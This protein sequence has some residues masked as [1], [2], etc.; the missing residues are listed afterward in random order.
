MTKDELHNF[1]NSDSKNHIKSRKFYIFNN[2]HD[3]FIKIMNH[4]LIFFNNR[5]ELWN[6]ILFHY[7][8]DI[9]ILPKCKNEKCNN[10][11]KFTNGIGYKIYCS[12]NCTQQSINFKK[13]RK[14]NNFKKYGVEEFMQTVDFKEKSKKTNLIKY[15]VENPMQNYNVKEKSKKTN[16]IKYG[17]ENPSQS[18]NV[19]NKKR[20]TLFNKKIIKYSKKLKILP[21]DITL[22]SNGFYVIKNYCKLHN[23]FEISGSNIY[24]RIHLKHE[25]IC[26]E[27]NPI[28]ENASILENE[29]RDYINNNLNVKTEKFKL[30]KKDVDIYLP[31]YK[32]GIEFDGLYWHSNKFK[33]DDCQLNKT[34]LCEKQNIKLLHVF[35]DEWLYK[36]EIVKSIIKSKL[37]LI[38]NKILA[39]ECTI[40]EIDK[41]TT[42]NFL[43]N[44]HIRGTINS[45]IR[46]GL[47]YDNDL[48]LITTFSNKTNNGNYEILRFCNKLNTSII[49]GASK[50]LNY[51]IKTYQ[52]NSI[53]SCIDR[54]Y[55]QGNLYK[56][57]GFKFIENTKPSYWYFKESYSIKY[58]KFNFRKDRL[59]SEGFDSNK[60][61]KEIMLERGYLRIYDCGNMKFKL[62]LN[63]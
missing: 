42:S 4:N 32:L 18:V 35:E 38:E 22:S 2:L 33:N 50:L 43:D 52:P 46:L 11:L 7:I 59:V 49:G 6:Q 58:N 5:I 39:S 40:K 23:E 47:F 55:S 31:D 26:T 62:T 21:E 14:I 27:C 9:K 63:N 34:N 13:L 3:E 57:L 41:I 48:V 10:N 12:A 53:I 54:R 45:K 25:N 51:F 30:G 56:Q 29:I 60:T 17:V 61:E 8:N 28:S 44:N 20:K 37:G 16:L 19:Q 15:G 1:L 24:N 36:K